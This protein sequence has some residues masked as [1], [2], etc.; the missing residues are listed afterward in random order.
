MTIER[1]VR[2]FAGSFVLLSLALGAPASPVFQSASW[3]WFT[4]F[5]GLNL[6]QSSLTGFCPLVNVLRALGVGKST[7]AAASP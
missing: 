4:G 7:P 1:Y 2:L 6:A 5:V 3:L